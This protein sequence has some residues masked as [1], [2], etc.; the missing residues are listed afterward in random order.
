MSNVFIRHNTTLNVIIHISYVSLL[1]LVVKFATCFG[2]LKSHH[3]VNI[4]IAI[5]SNYL[6][7]L[8]IDMYIYIY[9]I[10]T[11]IN[12]SSFRSR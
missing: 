7:A 1:V 2:S 3:Q 10:I 11:I 9:Y 6:I 4:L 12:I 5:F 8:Y